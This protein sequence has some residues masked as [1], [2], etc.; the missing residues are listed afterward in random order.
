MRAEAEST[1]EALNH[2]IENFKNS[3]EFKEKIFEGGFTSYYV[4][5]ENGWDTVRK[6]YPNLYWNSIIP[7]VSEDGATEDEAAPI[8]DATPTSEVGAPTASKDVSIIDAAL[9]QQDGGDDWWLV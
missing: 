6:L 5:Y 3:E 8:E 4:G 7:P 9:E 2:V 1:R